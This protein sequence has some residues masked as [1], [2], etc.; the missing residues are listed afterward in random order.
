MKSKQ[1]P[2]LFVCVLLISCELIRLTEHKK[3][4]IKPDPEQS[5]GS[6]FLLIQEVKD[7]NFV[8]VSKLFVPTDSIVDLDHLFE[9]REKIERFGR[10]IAKREVT[11]YKIDTLNLKEHLV[12]IEFDYLYE[13]FFVTQ[14]NDNWWLIKNFWEKK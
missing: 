6:V 5:I 9:L 11:A 13:Y 1:I 4:T 10:K 3:L 7:S 12:W 14:R 2:V 8:G